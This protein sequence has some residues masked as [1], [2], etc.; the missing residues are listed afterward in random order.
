M[1]VILA[2]LLTVI[3][4]VFYAVAFAG[5]AVDQEKYNLKAMVDQLTK[6]KRALEAVIGLEKTISQV[7]KQ[8][9]KGIVTPA[10]TTDS[11]KTIQDKLDK[12][13]EKARKGGYDKEYHKAIKENGGDRL[14]KEWKDNCNSRPSNKRE[15]NCY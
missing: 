4:G 10:Q 7:E 13:H 6:E 14:K 2:G 3:I 15:L 12:E 1:K 9:P 5:D 11:K 8:S